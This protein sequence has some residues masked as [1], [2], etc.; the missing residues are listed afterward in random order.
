MKSTIPVAL[1]K[2]FKG[3]G[4]GD[5]IGDPDIVSRM[6][7]TNMHRKKKLNSASDVAIPCFA[8]LF[9]LLLVNFLARIFIV[10]FR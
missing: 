2:P 6:P 9:L 8:T 3:G 4:N 5:L 10:L 1:C 7:V